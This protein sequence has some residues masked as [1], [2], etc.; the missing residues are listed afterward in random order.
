MEVKNLVKIKYTIRSIICLFLFLFISGSILSQGRLQVKL[1]QPPPNQLRATDL[2]KLNIYNSAKT[3]LEVI[4]NGTLDDGSGIVVD[5][6]SDIIQ[7]PPGNKTITYNDIKS[8]NISFKS[9]KW[10]E[11]FMMTGNAPSGEYE[12]CVIVKDRQGEELGSDC[13]DHKIEIMSPPELIS[14][15][16]QASITAGIPPVFTWML[17]TPNPSQKL[18]YKLKI[19]EVIGSQ[20]PTDALRRNPVWFEK[21]D[22]RTTILQ[23]PISAKKLETNKKYAWN[24]QSINESGEGVGQNEGLSQAFILNV[25]DQGG[26]TKSLTVPDSTGAGVATTAVV[27]DTISAGLNGE[28]KV[29]VSQITV[30]SDSSLSGKGKVRINWLMTSVAVEFKKIRI[31]SLKRLTSGAVVTSE[32]GSTSSSYQ[33]YPKAWAMSLLSGPGVANVVDNTVNWTNNLVDNLVSWT[34]GLNF[35]QPQI[36]YQ[37]NIPPPPIP[38][39]SLKMPFGL[40]FNNGN[41]KLVITEMVFKK[42]ES[43]IN[44]LL[45]EQFTKSG[46]VYKLGFAGKYFKIHQSSIEFSSGRVELVENI[47]IPNIQA[48]P[49]MKFIF[50]KGTSNTGCFAEW[51]STG[52]TNISLGMEIKFSRDWLLPSPTSSDTVKATIAGS[53]TSFNDIL[54][55]GTLQDCEIVGTNGLKMQPDSISLDL[56][57]TRNPA[58]MSFPKNYTNDTTAAMKLLWRGFYVKGFGLTLPDTWKTG[59]NPTQ[60]TASNLIID[61]YGIT[62][63]M[64]ATDI[65]TFPQGR[66]ANLSASLDTLNLSILKGSLTEGLAKGVLVLPISRDTITNT[67]KYSA[68]FSQNTTGSNFQFVII[69]T[70]PIDAD[71]LKGKITLLPTSNISAVISPSSK[72]FSINLNGTFKWDN[73]N[74]STP[75]IASALKG[76]KMELGFE[77]VGLIYKNTPSSDSLKFI[78]GNWSFASPQK[79]LANFPVSIKK[80]YYKSKTKI[81]PELLR[82]ALMIDVVADLTEDIGGSTTLG[83]G[84]AIEFNPST[85]KFKPKFTGV[86]VDSI[87]VHANLQAVRIDGRIALRNNDPVFGNGFLGQLNVDFTSVGVSAN[88]LVEFGNTNYQNGS[89]LY[90][91]WR[92]EA[93]VTIPPPGIPFLTGLAFRGFGGGAYYNMDA[94]LT[95][96]TKT[97]SGKKYT[98]KPKK[99]NLGLKIAATIA[100]T[101]KEETF[102]ADVSLNAQFSKA[103]GLILIGFTGD[104]YVGAGLTT[105]K[106]SKAN[107]FGNVNVGYNF[108]NKHFNLSAFV[109]VNAPPITTPTPTKL[110]LDINGKTNKWYFKFG[111]PNDL[112][113]VKVFGIN[114]YE[115]LMFGND[116]P[117]PTGFT[118]TFKNGYHGVFGVNP[119]MSVTTSGISGNSN[120]AT[121]RGL[122]LG[123]GFKFDKNIKFNIVGKFYA[124]IDLA[125]G[126]EL[127]L[128]F[129]EFN[130]QNCENPTERIG[131]NGWQAT[132]DIGFYAAVAATVTRNN[133]SWTV[134]ELTA[135]GWLSGRFPNPVYVAGAIQGSIKIGKV[136]NKYLLNTTFSRNFDYGT[137]CQ[138]VSSAGGGAVVNQ[139]DAAGDQGQL[140]IKYVLP[141]SQYSF[142]VSS[143]I[144]VSYGLIPNNVFDVVQQ[145]SDGTLQNRTFKMIVATSLKKKNS[146]GSLTSVSLLKRENNLG[147]FLYTSIVP[148]TINTSVQLSAA[149]QMTGTMAITSTT[150]NIALANNSFSG[151]SNL[152][153]ITYPPVPSNP[154]YGNLPPEPPAI[155]NN[156]EADKDY[157]FTVTAKLFEFINNSWV[158][159]KDKNN[160][161]VTQ[162]V[163]K[164]FRT[165]SMV[166]VSN[167]S[168]H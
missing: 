66:V 135:G 110:V 27:G 93:D 17:T 82:G 64:K 72:T 23:Y 12:I 156:L 13:I 97:S 38:D 163:T 141:S 34:N 94:T 59:A 167:T 100:T 2:W 8:G 19:V 142:P 45:Q 84:F 115:Y 42:N 70:G 106:R 63:K 164:L 143:P 114:L 4:L 129:S 139:G 28:F 80:V 151:I 54:L 79:F 10:R 108:P 155:T 39:N 99:S 165:G 91:Y 160:V 21:S 32:S 30:E 116:I 67:L 140:L 74:F 78:P 89:T 37:S 24:V 133:S 147:E 33:T 101:P 154:T 128:A 73:P 25:E 76:V 131:I 92:I 109:N 146:D 18:N 77:N 144:A 44:F 137:L 35:G 41:Q 14:P 22:I 3:N 86:D 50:K 96:S 121:G 47:T 98:F 53:G 40:Q 104:F 85:K 136:K 65:V 134:G 31:D 48:N 118:Q 69:P 168:V 68:T 7:I 132:G 161:T 15:A 58:F 149:Q 112:N 119:G 11:S 150:N 103:Q 49:K 60:V 120:T 90:R 122:A 125:A 127:N 56:S 9:G 61:D 5:G 148:F 124:N 123:I 57:D 29:I 88:A 111:E 138:G 126:A 102:N 62:V 105:A 145:N 157:V 6:K 71:V 162:T 81:S 107:I 130:G 83:A 152:G 26:I 166:I 51:D 1:I 55:T 158:S 36:N 20:S 46:T 87:E 113:T 153:V 159:A 117:A 43:K 75:S 16:D 95:T 52:I